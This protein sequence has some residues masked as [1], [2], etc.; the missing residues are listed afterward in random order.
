VNDEFLRAGVTTG[1]GDLSEPF[2]K[3][4]GDFDFRGIRTEH[5]DGSYRVVVVSAFDKCGHTN[6]SRRTGF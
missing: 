2:I 1:A 4:F 6:I 5:L 3:R